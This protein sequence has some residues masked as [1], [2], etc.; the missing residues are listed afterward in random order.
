[1]KPTARDIREQNEAMRRRQDQFR[2]AARYVADRLAAFGGVRKVAIIGSVAVP[3]KQEVPR[4]REYRRYRIEVLH[5]CSDLDLAV[6][7]SDLSDLKL[8]QKC[9][10]QALDDLAREQRITF[11]HHQVEVFLMEPGTDRYLGRLCRF[12][13]CP[14]HKLECLVPGCGDTPFLRHVDGFHFNPDVLAPD[15]FITLFDRSGKDS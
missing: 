10:I 3:L 5:E 9:R 2:V 15:R 1:M 14:K 6:W 4:F 13:Q 7:A 11:A 12:A 8:L